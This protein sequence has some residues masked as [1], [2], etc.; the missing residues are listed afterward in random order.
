MLS[1][2]STA[3]G[4]VKPFHIRHSYLPNSNEAEMTQQWDK[5]DELQSDYHLL[6]LVSVLAD[7]HTVTHSY[8]KS[9]NE[10]L[11]LKRPLRK[12]QPDGEY[13]FCQTCMF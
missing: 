7:T 8:T 1:Y 10:V 2:S 3:D 6:W 13:S 12:W 9:Q 11:I 4:A 5:K